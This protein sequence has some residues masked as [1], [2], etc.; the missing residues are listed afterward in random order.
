[1]NRTANVGIID[2]QSVNQQ[3][4]V[5]YVRQIQAY[6]HSSD[7]L[8]FCCLQGLLSY[9]L[10][11]YKKRLCSQLQPIRR[12]Y[13]YPFFMQNIAKMNYTT[14]GSKTGWNNVRKGFLNYCRITIK[15]TGCFTLS[16]CDTLQMHFIDTL[17]LHLLIFTFNCLLNSAYLLTRCKKVSFQKCKNLT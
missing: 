17:H 16:S 7:V 13:S 10:F 8:N 15:P 6:R 5:L 3:W 12:N 2:W 1:M 4:Q 11:P 9:K 14:N